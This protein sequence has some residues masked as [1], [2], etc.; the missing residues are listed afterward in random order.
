ML[1]SKIIKSP[2][3]DLKLTASEQGIREILFLGENSGLELEKQSRNAA[4]NAHIAQAKKELGEFFKGTRTSFD[5][6]LDI[7]AGTSFQQ[8]VWQALQKI[9]YGET[10]SYKE[11]AEAV[12]RPKA[13]R[14]VGSAN[15]VNPIPL[16]IPCHRVVASGGKLGGF[17]GGLEMKEALLKL[18]QG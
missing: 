18:E 11:V 12:G 8:D 15:R 1:V 14:A 9:P 10:R 16:I 13:C 17:A 2:V 6:P 4:A 3:G 5:V 7:D